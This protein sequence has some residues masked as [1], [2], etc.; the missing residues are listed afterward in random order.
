M[1]E[2]ENSIFRLRA[3]DQILGY[4]KQ[5]YSNTFY[6]KDLYGWSGKP[7]KGWIQKDKCTYLRDK[8]NQLIFEEDIVH[9]KD[10]PAIK[11]IYLHP[12]FDT[13]LQQFLFFDF[14]SGEAVYKSI[15]EVKAH[16]ESHQ[17]HRISYSFLN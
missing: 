16:F 5:I 13:G 3:D 6:S 14:K 10:G 8:N 17:L 11:D 4:S 7:I 1:N 9:A 15:D 12:V 2:K